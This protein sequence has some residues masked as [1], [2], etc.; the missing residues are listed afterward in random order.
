L[1]AE[2]RDARLLIALAA[3]A[4]SG[5]RQEPATEARAKSL[6]AQLSQAIAEVFE[7][8]QIIKGQRTGKAN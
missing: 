5:A 4:I 6:E 2:L 8:I 3:S 7:I 1:L